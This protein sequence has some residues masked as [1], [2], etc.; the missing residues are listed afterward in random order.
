[1]KSTTTPDKLF[2]K[3]LKKVGTYLPEDHLEVIQRAYEYADGAHTGQHRKSGEP[4]IEHPLQTALELSDIRLDAPT[5]AAALLHDVVEDCDVSIEELKAEF[6]SEIATLV[7]GVTKLTKEEVADEQARLGMAQDPDGKLADAATFNKL[8][9]IAISNTSNIRV[10]LI[11]LADRLHNMSTLDALD[12]SR[13]HKKAVETLRIYARLAHMLGIWEIKWKLEDLAFRHINRVEYREI[14]KML[15]AKRQEREDYIYRVRSILQSAL[16][17]AG[18]VCKVTGRAKHI[19]SIHRKMEKYRSENLGVDDIYDLFA[20]RIIVNNEDDCYRALRVVH[21]TWR[22]KGGQIDDYIYAPKKNGY[23]S[24]HTTVQ[25]VGMHPVEVQIRTVKMHRSAEYGVAAHWR[26]KGDGGTST[27]DSDLEKRM[28]QLRQTVARL[29]EIDNPIDFKESMQTDELNKHR[30]Q[31]FTPEA[32]LIDLPAGST[33][34]DFA[35]RIHTDLGLHCIGAKVNYKFVQ[36]NYPLQNSDTVEIMSNDK[37]SPRLEWLDHN[38]GYLKTE[39]AHREVRQWF[40]RHQDLKDK[41]QSGKD[42]FRKK[43]R[44]LTP[45]IMVEKVAH[46]FN[47]PNPDEFLAALGSSEITVQQ[48]ADRIAITHQP[49]EIDPYID[50]DAP[51]EMSDSS[52]V[53]GAG[54]LP[55]IAECCAPIIRGEKIIGYVTVDSR[56]D[57]HRRTCSNISAESKNLIHNIG[58]SQPQESYPVPV[59]V[60]ARDRKGL[61][62]DITTLV[63]NEDVNI[64]DCNSNERRGVSIITFTMFVNGILQLHS[65][66]SKMEAVPGVESV[67]RPRS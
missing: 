57:V 31:V 6:G 22:P 65:L 52:R 17:E 1:M 29:R 2:D 25:C 9:T 12:H 56:V 33:P 10:V 15:N 37:S 60:E 38:R 28:S 4:F 62:S 30:V 64:E 13:R 40:N 51:S 35:F 45:S 36:L 7:D 19:Y 67:S 3:L 46:M 44:R 21:A 26:Y 58:W 50:T 54:Q 39:Y 55:R 23:Q 49:T 48:V 47:Y 14:S 27:S 53:S 41:I 18:I 8:M 24:L 16:D 43:I 63:S 11:K 66:F 59:L 34:L 32:K 20:L 61:L 42:I 5:L